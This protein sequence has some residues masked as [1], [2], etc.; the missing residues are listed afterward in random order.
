MNDL[1]SCIDICLS[2]LATC[3]KCV[4]NCPKEVNQKCPFLC[5]NVID[6]CAVSVK[7]DVKGS[8][9]GQKLSPMCSEICKACLDECAKHK[10][11]HVSYKQ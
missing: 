1:K 11:H 3:K 8:M 4:A 2:C 5:L 9:F 6:T 10:T 7:F